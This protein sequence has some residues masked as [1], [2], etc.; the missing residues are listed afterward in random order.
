MQDFAFLTFCYWKKQNAP[1]CLG[2]RHIAHVMLS[3]IDVSFYIDHQSLSMIKFEEL[4]KFSFMLIK[5]GSSG[6]IVMKAA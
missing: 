1:I 2:V 6:A 4:L 5:P 3:L